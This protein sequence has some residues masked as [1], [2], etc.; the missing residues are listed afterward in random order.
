MYALVAL[1]AVISTYFLWCAAEA[2]GRRQQR[3]YLVAYGISLV[4]LVCSHYYS[5]LILP[6]QAGIVYRRLTPRGR[7]WGRLAAVSVLAPGALA[8]IPA[9]WQMFRQ[10]GAGSNFA[11]ISL[12]VLAP[13]LVNAFTLGLSVDLGRVW[14][15]DV[16]SAVTA[17]LGM[18]W[19]LRSRA[20]IARGGWLLPAFVVVPAAL[21]LIMNSV[22]PA[23]MTAR[24]MSL[25]S[26]GYLLLLSSGLA[27]LW[28]WRRWLG[29]AV[30]TVLFAGMIYSSVNYY[31]LPA[32]GKG[33][34]ASMGQYLREQIQ[35]G[36]LLLIE[37]SYM[38]RLYRY[39]LPI[40]AVEMWTRT[41]FATGWRAFP[42]VKGWPAGSEEE[43]QELSRQYRRIWLARSIPDSQVASWLQSHTFR[44]QEWGY[45]S[46]LSFLHLE[47]FV[48]QLPP[49][50]RLPE[51]TQHPANAAFGDIISFRGYEIGQAFQSGYAVPVT[52]Y[53]QALKP[54][55]RRYKYILRWVVRGG[56]GKEYVLAT[57]EHEPYDG[58][59]PT[60]VWTPGTTIREY[61]TIL[62]LAEPIP[63][64]AYLTL[65]MYD[66]ETLQK[67]P[68]TTA[69]G[70]EVGP[71]GEG[72]I[73]PMAQ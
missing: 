13:D 28:Q 34:L 71:D 54:P 1:L 36:D 40:D 68:V 16:V 21:L 10:P 66:A 5:V 41:G 17:L 24:H 23:Y 6:V 63:G 25:I 50:D 22:K 58:L 18:A 57:T 49:R 29:G 14:P 38:Q 33:D 37:P 30:A 48:P 4:T 42:K 64:Q 9:V 52:L 46:P 69:S 19:G 60:T 70:V 55:E 45:R 11:A 39:Y 43:L 3:R 2:E 65:Q 59:L 73:L 72:L 67:L 35:P 15:L 53:W 44:A 7:R 27:W 20:I 8:A 62:P 51:D 56:D 26:G 61:S 31:T 12:P 32:Y 47:L